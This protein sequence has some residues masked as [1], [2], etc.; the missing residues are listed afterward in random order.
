MSALDAFLRQP[1]FQWIVLPALIFLSRIVDVSAGTM[2]IILISRG[3]RRLAPL[4]GFFEVLVWLVTIRQLM[5]N[6][7]TPIAF[8]AYAGGFATGTLVGMII[9]DR[10][11]LGVVMIR[12]ITREGGAELVGFLRLQGYAATDL[13]ANGKEGPV[14]VILSIIPRQSLA[15]VERIIRD[16]NPNAFWSIEDVRSVRGGLPFAAPVSRRPVLPRLLAARRLV[17][18]V[19]RES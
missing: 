17:S 7:S 8:I 3:V 5:T 16:F 11:C 18:R 4:F 6:L 14:R 1:T 15:A 12:I 10:L 19:R 13:E 2:R 9:E